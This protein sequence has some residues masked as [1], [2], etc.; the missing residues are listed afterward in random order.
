MI[1]KDVTITITLVLTAMMTSLHLDIHDRHHGVEFLQLGLSN[2][3]SIQVPSSTLV[4]QILLMSMSW[5]WQFSRSRDAMKITQ[6]ELRIHLHKEAVDI[7]AFSWRSS[8][9]LPWI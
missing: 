9:L 5:D 6:S 2:G 8:E 1:V 4:K 7:G 3:S